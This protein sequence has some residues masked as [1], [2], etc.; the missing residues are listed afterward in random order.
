MVLTARQ[1]L[2]SWRLI[3]SSQAARLA[4]S[5]ASALSGCWAGQAVEQSL[6]ELVSI[7]VLCLTCFLRLLQAPG[8][9]LGKAHQPL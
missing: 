8:E 2:F 6:L 4:S 3:N 5:G 9:R 7:S 1:C